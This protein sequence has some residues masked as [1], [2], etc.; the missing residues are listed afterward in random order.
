MADKDK[1]NG[2]EK[3]SRRRSKAAS[4]GAVESAPHGK[5]ARPSRNKQAKPLDPPR[6]RSER[7]H[8]GRR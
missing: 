3:L 8:S 7:R 4:R 6:K 1:S 5:A 2:I